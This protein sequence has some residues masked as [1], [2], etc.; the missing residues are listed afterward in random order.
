MT[1]NVAVLAGCTREIVAENTTHT[2]HLLVQ[3]D[4]DLSGVFNAWDM[5]EQEFIRVNG[6][7]FA[8][9]DADEQAA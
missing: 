5:D 8:F 3:P 6:W 7:L 4:A 1:D 2:L 9:E